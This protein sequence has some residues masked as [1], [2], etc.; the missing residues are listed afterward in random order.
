M[1]LPH[2]KRTIRWCEQFDNY[3]AEDWL[4]QLLDGTYSLDEMRAAVLQDRQPRL[5]RELDD[6][7]RT[8]ETAI[9]ELPPYR[10]WEIDKRE[11]EHDS[12]DDQLVWVHDDLNMKVWV[13]FG[14]DVVDLEIDDPNEGGDY[15]RGSSFAYVPAAERTPEWFM[16][17]C[18]KLLDEEVEAYGDFAE[19]YPKPTGG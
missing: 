4:A 19:Q 1:T 18:M 17:G 12:Y 2:Q 8:L 16:R 15:H 5:Q 14:P 6:A 10:G 11:R 13:T 3:A 7:Q 9:L